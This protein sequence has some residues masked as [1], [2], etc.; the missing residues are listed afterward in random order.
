MPKEKFK[1]NENNEVA[2]KNIGNRRMQW[3]HFHERSKKK[4]HNDDN[5]CFNE[6]K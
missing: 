3:F 1:F 2:K 6:K 4:N 5:Y